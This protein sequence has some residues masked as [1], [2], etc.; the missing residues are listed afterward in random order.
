VLI[1]YPLHPPGK[2]DR[3]RIEH[4]PSLRVPCLFISGTRDSFG[5]P[6]ELERHTA[7]IPGP[8]E[9]VWIEGKG[10]DLKGADDVLSAAVSRWMKALR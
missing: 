1:S 5:T 3:L 10:H 8:V 9:H 7:A 6:D 2:A 4:L